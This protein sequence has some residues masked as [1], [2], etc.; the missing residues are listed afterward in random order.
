MLLMKREMIPTSTSAGLLGGSGL[1][2]ASMANFLGAD[3]FLGLL[4]R[5][6]PRPGEFRLTSPSMS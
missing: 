2:V 1:E 3:N 6:G 4:L 5:S